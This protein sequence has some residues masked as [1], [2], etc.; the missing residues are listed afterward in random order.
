[1]SHDE[2]D[3]P[4]IKQS[5][6]SVILFLC[7]CNQVYLAD[8]GMDRRILL[9]KHWYRLLL[10][11]WRLHL[12]QLMRLQFRRWRYCLD[13]LEA[14]FVHWTRSNNRLASF[15]LR[16]R[17]LRWMHLGL[18]HGSSFSH[19]TLLAFVWKFAANDAWYWLS[20]RISILCKCGPNH[21]TAA[22]FGA[23]IQLYHTSIL[24]ETCLVILVIVRLM[25]W[26]LRYVN[27]EIY[28]LG[29]DRVGFMTRFWIILLLQDRFSHSK[30]FHKHLFFVSYSLELVFLRLSSF[31]F[32][33]RG[34]AEF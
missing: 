23:Q 28:R 31:F 11:F 17:D 18:N 22:A 32:Q 14:G 21:H 19:E 34:G 8:F 25:L 10:L 33:F 5:C 13:L 26:K 15:E 27:W 2:R 9:W 3:T 6:H 24:L 12:L 30:I 1:M 20:W 29:A 4:G 7:R 16:D